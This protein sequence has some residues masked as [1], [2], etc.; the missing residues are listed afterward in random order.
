MRICAF[1]DTHGNDIAF[2]QALPDMLAEEPDQYLFLGDIC[3]YYYA[4]LD[5]FRALQRLPNLTAI[6]GNHDQIFMDIQGGNEELRQN[7]LSRYGSSM[8]KL[9]STADRAFCSW[10]AE[11]PDYYRDPQG[12]FS[13]F[14][15]SPADHLNGYVY[16]DTA[17]DD[18]TKRTE[19]F[20]FL[21]HTHY[22]MLR[23]DGYMT[24]INPGSLG[25]PRD[26]NWP[27]YCVVDTNTGQTTFKS[28][29]Y[30][31]SALLARI[32][33]EQDHN[34]YLKEVLLRIS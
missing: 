13:C 10:L 11:L 8:E 1:A 33:Q 9:S 12:L 32:D 4:Q 25:Q 6:K 2:L 20:I 21:A 24:I 29:R 31:R 18:I 30:D 19:R 34:R 17:L 14:H 23:K 7:Y 27:T 16:P 28:I 3:G 22:P 5:I 15:G 26:G